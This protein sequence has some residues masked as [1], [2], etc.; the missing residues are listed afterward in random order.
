V[1]HAKARSLGLVVEIRFNYAGADV[2][3]TIVINNEAGRALRKKRVA[4]LAAQVLDCV[5]DFRTGDRVCV[6]FR[7]KD[8]GQYAVATGIV[9]CDE[10]MLR[11]TKGKSADAH[12]NPA[13][14]DGF[15]V[16]IREQDLELLWSSTTEID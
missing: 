14:N 1:R 3:G 2:R 6:A 15:D 10:A 5:G 13:E 16:V 12:G 8:G 7:G 4:V 11:R 9:R